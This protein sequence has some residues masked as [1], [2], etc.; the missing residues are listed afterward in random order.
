MYGDADNHVGCPYR[1]VGQRLGE[2]V[3]QVE[4][5][6]GHGLDDSGLMLSA[7][8]TVTRPAAWWRSRPAAIW[9]CVPHRG[10]VPEHRRERS[11]CD[12]H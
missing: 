6:L 3:G 12:L 11:R 8:R 1:V 7:G 5:D 2:L 9:D 10:W 4:S